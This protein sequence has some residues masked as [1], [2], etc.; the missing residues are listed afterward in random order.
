MSTPDKS[1]MLALADARVV[2][3]AVN[4]SRVVAIFLS[5]EGEGCR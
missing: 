1:Y 5:G 4:A 2:N 3:R